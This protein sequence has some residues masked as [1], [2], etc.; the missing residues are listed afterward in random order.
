MPPRVLIS[1]SLSPAAAQI[2]RLRGLDV[3]FEPTLGKDK[4]KLAA[5]IGDYDGLAIR[6]ATKVTAEI[7][8]RA[9]RLKVVGRAGIGVDNVD[10]AA[11]TARGVIVMN[12]PFGNSVTTAEHA[13]ALMFALAREIPAADA[14]TQAG[15]WEKNRFLGVEITGKTLGIIGCGNIGANV[16]ERG[17]GLK[18][19]V[20]AFDPYLTEERASEL[21]VEKVELDD[22]LARADFITLHTPLTPQTKNIL[23]AESIARTCR[24]VRIINCA[25]GGLIDEEAL[26][27]ALDDGHVAGAA[28]DVFAQEPATENPLFGHPHVVCTPHLGASTSEA[29]E[30]V[31]L[32]IAEQMADYLTRGAI[33]NAVNFPSISAE[34]APRL[35]PFVELAEKLGL[36]VGQVARSGVD[37][38][39]IVY[40]GVVALQK[41][42]PITA[43][44]ISGLLRPILEDVNPVSAPILAKER[45][46]SVEEITREAQGDYESLV[47][48]AAH[49]A[50]GVI[51]VSGTVFHDGKPRIVGIGDTSVDAEFA[52]SMIY[53]TNEDRPGFI[54]RFAGVLGDAEVN[55]AT[56]A[57]GR[58]RPG[59]GAVALVAID[60]E[61][62]AQALAALK[63]LP[64]VKQATTLKF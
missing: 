45:G 28:L 7:I 8:E 52:K 44:A 23:S 15:K 22:L 21:G 59:G 55:I 35:K 49:T 30:K 50:E 38:L 42:R 4:D 17:L 2:F 54:G 14:S 18:M 48:L 57:L 16:A 31:A 34:E 64:G 46:L 40:E 10:V 9:P 32:Q 51:S 36:F 20:I 25:R 58:D 19:R 11:A 60:G 24:G 6:S 62:P 27:K 39:S 29:Q 56:F 3:D 63:G 37:R 13:I 12:T 43:A 1:D 53:V 33:V 47:T 61:L 5:A 41:T 26:R